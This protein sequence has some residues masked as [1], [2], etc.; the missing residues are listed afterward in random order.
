MKT[1]IIPSKYMH[2]YY[3]IAYLFLQ[4]KNNAFPRRKKIEPITRFNL[5]KRAIAL[6][7]KREDPR[8]PHPPS[9]SRQSENPGSAATSRKPARLEN[10]ALGADPQHRA[11]DPQ[12]Q[13]AGC[14]GAWR[15]N[16]PVR[17]GKIKMAVCLC[18]KNPTFCVPLEF[19]HVR[20]IPHV[21]NCILK[22]YRYE[23]ICVMLPLFKVKLNIDSP[24]YFELEMPSFCSKARRKISSSVGK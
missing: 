10:R 23:K 17:V 19:R 24:L 2:R 9:N 22:G 18:T 12:N 14:P 13:P 6:H 3:V 1:K 11:S 16:H 5:K 15:R 4:R 8:S 7:A 20:T 21:Q